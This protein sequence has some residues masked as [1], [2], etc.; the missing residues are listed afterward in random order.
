VDGTE[1]SDFH[2]YQ[3]M[4]DLSRGRELLLDIL[5]N[6]EKVQLKVSPVPIAGL[7]EEFTR[8]LVGV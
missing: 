8:Y 3:S 4:I 7:D 2:E 5:R 1:I 6:G